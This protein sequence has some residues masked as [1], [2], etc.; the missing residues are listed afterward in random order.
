MILMLINTTLHYTDIQTHTFHI[1]IS[2]MKAKKPDTCQLVN[3][4]VYIIHTRKRIRVVKCVLQ[5]WHPEYQDDKLMK[6][7][8]NTPHF[9][10][11]QQQLHPI[12][13]GTTAQ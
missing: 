4:A 2:Y 6:T 8:F 11:I 3:H 5:D 13:V 9:S 12:D 7:G 1:H 10:S